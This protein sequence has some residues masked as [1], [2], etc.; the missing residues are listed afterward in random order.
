MSW[1]N[2][3][4]AAYSLGSWVRRIGPELVAA[5]LIPVQI[6]GTILRWLGASIGRGST[7]Y[8][9]LRLTDPQRLT[10]GDNT[11]VNS[12]CLFDAAGEIEIGSDVS[13]GCGV[14]LITRAHDIGPPEH[15]CGTNRYERIAIGDGTWLGA[16]VMVLPG[17]T[18]G[19]GVV[20]GAG[21]LVTKNLEA[22]GLYL[23]SPARR[24]RELEPGEGAVHR[25]GSSNAAVAPVR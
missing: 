23:G 24:V 4:L 2:V 9:G 12:D 6:R 13:L 20:V 14:K 8:A 10:I 21:A 19:T 7:I 1:R 25:S 17:V 5:E 22:N 16:G 11:F 18:V 3:R 15:R